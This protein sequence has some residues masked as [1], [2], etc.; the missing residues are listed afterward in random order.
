MS[1]IRPE[2]SLTSAVIGAVMAG[3]I[4]VSAPL[5]APANASPDSSVSSEDSKGDKKRTPGG[6]AINVE[7]TSP[8]LTTPD[9]VFYAPAGTGVIKGSKLTYEKAVSSEEK[10]GVNK[11]N[12]WV[13]VEWNNK[14]AKMLLGIEKALKANGIGAEWD[15]EPAAY[16]ANDKVLN[17][18]VSRTTQGAGRGYDDL[19]A[20]GSD[21][22]KKMVESVK[23]LNSKI[24]NG[25]QVD[26]LKISDTMTHRRPDDTTTLVGL[27]S[28]DAKSVDV[29]TYD[30]IVV[31]VTLLSG[32]VNSYKRNANSPHIKRDMVQDMRNTANDAVR[33]DAAL[34]KGFSDIGARSKVPG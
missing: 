4:T 6:A 32:M 8:Y 16:W 25:S 5:A 15:R 31:P 26:P 2:R 9:G 1:L 14:Y 21:L 7:L 30:S 17:R 10:P 29:A 12:L 11:Q 22:Y 28:Q 19:M 34:W 27:V 24:K 13:F 33:Q 3:A 18:N 20:S 23:N